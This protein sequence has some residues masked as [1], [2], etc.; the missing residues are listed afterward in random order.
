MAESLG[1]KTSISIGGQVVANARTKT[2]NV[3]N[4]VIDLTAD[5]DNGLQRLLEIVGQRAF[6]ITVDGLEVGDVIYDIAVSDN[7]ITEVILNDT[8]N[9]L[10]G[11][12]A[13]SNYS[14]GMP[15]NEAMTFS[16]SFSSS[17]DFVKAAV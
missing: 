11:N 2:L 7:I 5:G 15:Y 6:E 9:T 4:E 12:F 10:T 3:N 13:I 1:R 14:R 8:V 16:C 17:G